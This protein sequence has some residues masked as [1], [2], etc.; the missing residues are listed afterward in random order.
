MDIL[1]DFEAESKILK[2]LTIGWARLGVCNLPPREKSI[3]L[4]C[5]G[6]RPGVDVAGIIPERTKAR[7]RRPEAPSDAA[8]RR[9]MFAPALRQPFLMCVAVKPQPLDRPT[10]HPRDQFP[11]APD[12]PLLLA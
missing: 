4:V 8:G 1:R 2:H 6:G 11:A 10:P 3:R 9:T 7:G 5:G 12:A